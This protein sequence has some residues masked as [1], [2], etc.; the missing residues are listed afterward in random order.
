[1]ACSIVKVGFYSFFRTS[2]LRSK[3][4]LLE[5]ERKT[6]FFFAFCSF[7]RTFAAARTKNLLKQ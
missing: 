6:R 2:A 4:L 5:N 3:V 7:I 1:M